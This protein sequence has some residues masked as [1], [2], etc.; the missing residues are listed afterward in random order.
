[1]KS[2]LSFAAVLM[3]LVYGVCALGAAIPEESAL[4]V[5]GMDPALN[6][7]ADRSDHKFIPIPEP[8]GALLIATFGLALLIRRRGRFLRL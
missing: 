4:M 8:G 6:F 5:Q 1:M 7:S 3:T 2:V